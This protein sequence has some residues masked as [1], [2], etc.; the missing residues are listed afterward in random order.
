MMVVLDILGIVL[1]SVLF[2]CFIVLVNT[3][4]SFCF[5]EIDILDTSALVNFVAKSIAS[6]NDTI[7]SPLFTQL[8]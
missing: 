3:T 2:R 6:L 5:L 8:F 7:L 4:F 1:L